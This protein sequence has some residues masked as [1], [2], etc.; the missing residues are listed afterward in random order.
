MIAC[1]FLITRDNDFLEDGAL[2]LDTALFFGISVDFRV[3]PASFIIHFGAG[4]LCALVSRLLSILDPEKVGHNTSIVR[5]VEARIREPKFA[6][7]G[8]PGDDV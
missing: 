4:V 2:S 3:V 5:I 6:R 1:A 8:A 7:R